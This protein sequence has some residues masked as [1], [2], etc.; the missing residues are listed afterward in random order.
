[1]ETA[2][3]LGWSDGGRGAATPSAITVVPIFL[4]ASNVSATFLG[5]TWTAIVFQ[6][7][8]FNEIA[9]FTSFEDL[10]TGS[11][12]PVLDFF[13]FVEEHLDCRRRRLQTRQRRSLVTTEGI[14]VAQRWVLK[15]KVA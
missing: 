13:V 14:V 3:L 2:G 4:G 10:S 15:G 12:I 9:I 5:S 8:F 6:P 1:V 11:I 7:D